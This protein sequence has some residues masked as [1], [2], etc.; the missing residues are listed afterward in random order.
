MLCLELKGCE[1]RLDKSEQS[2]N[3]IL[4]KSNLE[5]PKKLTFFGMVNE[6]NC[7]SNIQYNKSNSDKEKP[8]KN[9]NDA[10]FIRDENLT[11]SRHKSVIYVGN[12]TLK[13]INDEN[14]KQPS[15]KTF[16]K[17]VS[18]EVLDEHMSLVSTENSKI[19]TVVFNDTFS[20]ATQIVNELT[21][22]CDIY[23]SDTEDDLPLGMEAEYLTRNHSIQSKW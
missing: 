13:T 10:V 23:W 16:P 3:F 15:N 18:K 21:S 22:P 5:K 17:I 2:E 4:C 7:F 8:D 14:E 1:K 9:V 20:Y 6:Q 19:V 12:S 11:E